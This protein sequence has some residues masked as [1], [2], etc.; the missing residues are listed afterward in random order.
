MH[1]QQEESKFVLANI[2]I[3]LQEQSEIRLV[4]LFYYAITRMQKIYLPSLWNQQEQLQYVQHHDS[5]HQKPFETLSCLVSCKDIYV[6]KAH[7]KIH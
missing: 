2:S 4:L 5:W 3:M 7:C 6:Y 1:S